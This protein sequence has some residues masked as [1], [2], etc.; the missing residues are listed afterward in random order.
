MALE[1][2]NYLGGA[3]GQFSAWGSSTA[4]S[5]EPGTGVEGRAQGCALCPERIAMVVR[6]NA[7][8]KAM[9]AG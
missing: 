7:T 8:S 3:V 4:D 9:A 6:G 1:L 5:G 2:L